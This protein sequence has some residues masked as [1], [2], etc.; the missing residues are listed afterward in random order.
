[1]EM[2]DSL[3]QV[4]P[5]NKN[6]SSHPAVSTAVNTVVM[7]FGHEKSLSHSK[8]ARDTSR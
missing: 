7:G 3:P 5:Q 2:I 8:R 1:M 4:Q 6:N